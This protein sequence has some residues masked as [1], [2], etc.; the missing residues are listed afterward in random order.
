M[1][2]I[3]V[4]V[5]RYLEDLTWLETIKH[6][7][8]V[9]NKK[10]CPLLSLSF[11]T[12]DLPNV[13]READTYL[14]HIIENYPNFPEYTVF[15]QANIA[16]HVNEV[17]N[18]VNRIKDIENGIVVTM[19]GYIGLNEL[20]VNQGWNDIIDFTDPSHVSLP[21][22][23]W[24]FRL[25]AKPPEKNIIRCNYCAIFQV[26]RENI[27]FH[28]KTFYEKL[29]EFLLAEENICPYILE[30]FWTSIFNGKTKSILDDDICD[31]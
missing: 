21:L 5:A 4:V 30:R 31:H 29:L 8:I 2:K 16:D 7:C 11:N 12:I 22:K 27:L 15:T 18:F 24:W 6:L 13:G 26:S 14:R 25:Y 10:P 28:S 23:E 17:G 9:Y 19:D 1:S 3:Q 20:R